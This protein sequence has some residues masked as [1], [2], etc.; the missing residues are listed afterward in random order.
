[1][2]LNRFMACLLAMHVLYP[3]PPLP[4]GRRMLSSDHCTSH[5]L[6]S[7]RSSRAPLLPLRPLA[8]EVAPA[9]VLA[10]PADSTTWCGWLASM[11]VIRD[12]VGS[13]AA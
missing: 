11:E 1:M 7:V 8:A 4:I 12:N 10:L 5:S 6:A 3:G 13:A 9:A 2:A